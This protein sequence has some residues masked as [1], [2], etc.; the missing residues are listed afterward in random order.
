M[1]RRP[2][3]STQSRSSAA[4][5]VYK[6]QRRSL[7]RHSQTLATRPPTTRGEKPR[8]GTMRIALL[9]TSDTDLLSARASGAD[10]VFANPGRPGHQSMAETIE[11]ADLV[12][13][14]ILGSPQD[15]CSGFARIRDSGMPMVMLGGEQQPSITIGIPE[16]RIR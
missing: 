14:R 10:Y 9:S 3:R 6:R 13:G 4:S 2:P 7:L 15:L 1:I 5:D 8:G 11:G 12:V 16:S